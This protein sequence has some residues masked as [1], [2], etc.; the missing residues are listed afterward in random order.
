MAAVFRLQRNASGRV[1]DFVAGS[2][3]ERQFASR[4]GEAGRSP[5]RAK[6]NHSL[7][8]VERKL[9]GLLLQQ[10]P[11]LWITLNRGLDHAARSP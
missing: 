8:A 3:C 6:F 7:G 9:E 11:Q 10:A 4:A 1:L 2:R 5:L